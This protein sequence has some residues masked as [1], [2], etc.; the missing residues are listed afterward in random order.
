VGGAAVPLSGGEA[1]S[2]FN[3]LWL[4]PRPTSILCGILI[5]P[6]ICPHHRWAK[7]WG[8][9]VPLFG[10]LGPHLHEAYDH[11]KLHLDPSN[12]LATIQQCHGQDRTT[13]T[14]V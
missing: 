6:T 12:H 1:R 4:E 8:G 11:M 7:N 10:G 14:M 2:P 13:Q 3:T 9:A 5:L